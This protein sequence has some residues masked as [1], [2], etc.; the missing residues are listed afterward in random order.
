MKMFIVIKDI[1]DKGKS[2]LIKD[3]MRSE[4]FMCSTGIR[5]G[6]KLSPLMFA[7]FFI[8]FA[9]HMTKVYHD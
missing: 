7:L 6:D 5:Q 9:K 2:C 3:Y 8:D 4:Y 1:Y